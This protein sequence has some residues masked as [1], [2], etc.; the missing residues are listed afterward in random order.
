MTH[1]N[2][3]FCMDDPSDINGCSRVAEEGNNCSMFSCE[4][5]LSL[6]QIKFTLYPIFDIS[7][8]RTVNNLVLP[9]V[10]SPSCAPLPP[11]L[12]MNTMSRRHKFSSAVKWSLTYGPK[13][14][15]GQCPAAASDVLIHTNHLRQHNVIFNAGHTACFLLPQCQMG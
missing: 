12:C 2:W 15:N 5:T 9:A 1:P 8:S 13:K 4:N 14:Q 10:N 6:C 3:L 11:L 7:Y